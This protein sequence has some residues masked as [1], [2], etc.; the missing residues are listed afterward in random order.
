MSQFLIKTTI[1]FFSSSDPTDIL[2]PLRQSKQINKQNTHKTESQYTMYI[3]L[4][5]LY[6]IFYSPE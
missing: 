6:V 1:F 2:F 3:K 4:F 5:K